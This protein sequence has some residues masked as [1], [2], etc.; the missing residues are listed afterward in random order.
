MTERFVSLQLKATVPYRHI[1][2]LQDEAEAVMPVVQC[3]NR[4]RHCF[5]AP[6]IV[7]E[8]RHSNSLSHQLIILRCLSV[9]FTET[10]NVWVLNRTR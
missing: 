10:T 4:R 6:E 7:H 5:A 2:D 1:T 9:V 3:A 8:S